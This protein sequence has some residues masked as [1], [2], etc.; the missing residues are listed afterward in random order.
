MCKVW[1]E[2]CLSDSKLLL[3]AARKPTFLTKA[4]FMGLF[5]LTSS[6]AA[7]FPHSSRPRRA[8][9][10]MYCYTKEAIDVAIPFIGNTAK[11]RQRLADR[12]IQQASIESSLGP[13]WRQTRYPATKTH[14]L[15]CYPDVPYGWKRGRW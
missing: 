8:G 7:L 5:G 4:S 6:E 3:K 12:A 13:N 9:G 1:R 11:W 15:M 14:G 10:Y 2:V